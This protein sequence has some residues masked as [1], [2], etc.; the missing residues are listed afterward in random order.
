MFS[1]V[2]F[3]SASNSITQVQ[4]ERPV[5]VSSA[6]VQTECPDRVVE[7]HSLGEAPSGW[8]KGQEKIFFPVSYSNVLRM[9]HLSGG[10]QPLGYTTCT[11]SAAVR[12]AKSSLRRAVIGPAV[13]SPMGRPSSCTTA[14]SSP[15]VPEQNISSAR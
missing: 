5:R 9:P 2:Q 6:S 10:F 13:P 3:S 15:I 4:T 11:P 14:A 8:K 12:C 1:L 7:N